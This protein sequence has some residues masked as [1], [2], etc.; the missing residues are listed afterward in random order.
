M[1]DIETITVVRPPA[2][3]KF[4]DPVAGAAAETTVPGCQFAPGPSTDG[5]VGTNTVDADATV[6]APPNVDIRA[7]DQVRARGQLWIVAG[8]P[9]FWG[10]FGTVIPLRRVTG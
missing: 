4:G 3:G 9:Q 8:A 1:A 7:T 10:S 6:Y 2:R 5:P